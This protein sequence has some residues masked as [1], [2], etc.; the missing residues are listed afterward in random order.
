[1]QMYPSEIDDGALE[2]HAAIL[3][4]KKVGTPKSRTIDQDKMIKIMMNYSLEKSPYLNG[5]LICVKTTVKY[6]YILIMNYVSA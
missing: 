1:M 5:I 2:M 6:K 4:E 3:E